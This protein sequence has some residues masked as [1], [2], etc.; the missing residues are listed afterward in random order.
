MFPLQ[1]PSPATALA[2]SEPPFPW[3]KE[4]YFR[5][6]VEGDPLL[7][8]DFEGE[9]QLVP[10][11]EALGAAG[12]GLDSLKERLVTCLVRQGRRDLLMSSNWGSR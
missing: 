8:Y 1:H 12:A 2:V 6:V 5:P 11:T 7:Q 3:E 10:P 4:E 9:G